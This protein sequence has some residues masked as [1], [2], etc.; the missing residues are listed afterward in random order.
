M[1]HSYFPLFI[2]LSQF[3]QSDLILIA[4]G[5]LILIWILF[6]V[7]KTL[8]R[9]A[10]LALLG[11]ALYFIWTGKT[12]D[13]LLK[14][15]LKTAVKRTSIS[16]LHDKFCTPEKKDRAM[17]SCIVDPIYNDVLKRYSKRD[18]KDMDKELLASETLDSYENQKTIIQDCLKD[19]KEDKL[20]IIEL[21]K[22]QIAN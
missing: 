11:L 6:K 12:P 19:K 5:G 18:L 2:D 14:T 20:K 16:N 9:V 1:I 21:L 7:A 17:C 15:G 10:I 4:V 13:A 22:E 3:S 8:V